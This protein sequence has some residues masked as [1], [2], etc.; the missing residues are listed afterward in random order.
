MEQTQNHVRVAIVGGGIAGLS[1][2]WYLQQQGET[3]Y[4]LIEQSPRWGGKILTEVVEGYGDRPFIIDAGPESF[5]TR[6]P[7]ALNLAREA[8]VEYIASSDETRDIFILSKG[9]PIEVPLKPLPFVTSPIM[10]PW[11]KLRMAFEP[12]VPRKG[13]D[14]DESLAQFTSRRLGKEA[15]E[16]FI[17]PILGGI[18]NTNPEE[19]SILTTSPIM[20]E[21]EAQYGSLFWALFARMRQA[22]KAPP[23]A[24][25][26]E[27]PPR[28]ITF[29]QGAQSLV[30]EVVTQLNGRLCLEMG[31]QSI[32]RE[33]GGYRLNLTD[34]AAM[35]ADS[36]VLA[37][38]ANASAAMLGDMAP[39][40]AAKLAQIEHV[41]IGTI[42]LIF[43]SEDAQTERRMQGLMIPRREKRAIDAVTWTSNKLP[44]RSPSDYTLIRVFFGGGQPEIA[45]LSDE[46]LAATVVRELHD[47]VGISG[48]PV[49]YRIARWLD[50][51]PQ[52]A[53]GHLDHVAAI[54]R[55]L[56]AGVF[57]TGS[58]YR[59]L[60]V[61]DCIAQ[62]EQS[63]HAV[64]EY[65][66]DLN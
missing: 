9:R 63:A 19:Q 58:S 13:D 18:Y 51:Y 25:G 42:S 40:V 10:S 50:S 34:G 47:L 52:A 30:D 56:P 33:N 57:V 24:D 15:L 3:A 60:A 21:L 36:V 1:A 5:V 32:S 44:D 48:Q 43:K 53:V 35:T 61:P 11:G 59:G 54:E 28:F 27:K 46:E 39:E 37:T 38:P 22:R 7:G 64:L 55:A 26:A 23:A 8:G 4:A 20:R 29:K 2:A 41:H 65:I 49:E 12:L 14:A 62:G 45:E 6:K 17:G 16:K 66:A 31:V